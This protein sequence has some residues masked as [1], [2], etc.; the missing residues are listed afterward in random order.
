V[1]KRKEVNGYPLF[2]DGVEQKMGMV[3][4]RIYTREER[5]GRDLEECIVGFFLKKIKFLLFIM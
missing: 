4:E 2:H 3:K 5:R 1:N